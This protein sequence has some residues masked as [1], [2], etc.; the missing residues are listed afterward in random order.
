MI[1]NYDLYNTQPGVFWG[2]VGLASLY[3][4]GIAIAANFFVAIGEPE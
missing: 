4:L 2:I 3:T 1:T